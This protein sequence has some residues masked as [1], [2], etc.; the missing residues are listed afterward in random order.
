MNY[1]T[2][3]HFRFLKGVKQQTHFFTAQF[4]KVNY[5]I[6]KGF[7]DYLSSTYVIKNQM[8]HLFD[9]EFLYKKV[10]IKNNYPDKYH[11]MTFTADI[12]DV[13]QNKNKSEGY[14]NISNNRFFTDNK[15]TI[16]TYFALKTTIL[17][18]F[19]ETLPIFSN[20][21]KIII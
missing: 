19:V 3:N 16:W 4:N 10:D 7:I 5:K 13:F 12:I 15:I 8:V 9:P 14:K 11:I 18:F 21:I 20:H 1:I 17:F 6:I 2:Y